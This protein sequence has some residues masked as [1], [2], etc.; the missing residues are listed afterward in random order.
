LTA[1]TTATAGRPRTRSEAVARSREEATTRRRRFSPGRGLAYLALILLSALW[2]LPF[3]W[4]VNTSF[5]SETDASA[6]PVTIAP[7][8][9]YTVEAYSRLFAQG[10]VP[11]WMLN[12]TIIAAAVTILTLIVSTL[13]AYAFSRLR[14][15]GK[16]FFWALTI[17]SIMIPT[18]IFIVPLFDQMLALNLVDTYWG[19]ILPQLISPVMIFV[20][21]R[22]FDE[23]P[24]ELEQAALVDGASR[25]RIFTQIV[26][27]LSRPIIAAVAIFVF[28]GAWNNFLW[29]FIVTNDPGLMT[30]PV[31]LQTVTPGYGPI[32]ALRMAQAVLA[33]LPLIIVFLFFQ[34]QIIKGISTTGI[35]GT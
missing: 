14:F 31:G 21:K 34:R 28:I 30:L 18:Q 19:V 3:L 27:P 26:L 25:L 4:A 16:A 17:G 1:T 8:G 2:L 33:A 22:F 10:N 6:V 20:L 32:F 7:A 29:P 23:I 12:S 13:A 9:G 35:A 15:P 24:G 5:K 11:L